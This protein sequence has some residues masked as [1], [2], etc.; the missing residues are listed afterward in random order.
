MSFVQTIVPTN[1][2][3]SAARST[4]DMIGVMLFAMMFERVERGRGDDSGLPHAAAQHLSHAARMR[5][6]VVAPDQHRA[7]R[8]PP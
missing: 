7:H 3:E 2:L 5:D 1:P 8:A 4:P 6:Q